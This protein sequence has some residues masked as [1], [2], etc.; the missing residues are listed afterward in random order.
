MHYLLTLIIIAII[1]IILISNR[2]QSDYKI[3]S[4][5]INKNDDKMPRD[6]LAEA[7]GWLKTPKS[8]KEMIEENI[9]RF[10]T[11]LSESRKNALKRLLDIDNDDDIRIVSIK[12]QMKLLLYNERNIPLNNIKNCK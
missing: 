7:Q 9:E 10:L 6:F 8:F 3:R 11:S 5:N 1:A 12:E 4:A 2:K